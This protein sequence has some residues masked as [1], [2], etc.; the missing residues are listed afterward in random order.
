MSETADLV[1][2]H[3]RMFNERDWSI[4]SRIYSPDVAVTE[5]A[6]GTVVGIDAVLAHSQGFLAGFPDA[7]LEIVTLIDDGRRVVIEG[8]FVGTNTGPLGTPQGELPATGRSMRLPYADVWESEAGRITNHRVYYD[9]MDFAMQLG[10]M[11]D[12]APAT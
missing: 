6:F 10:L 1:R 4:A 3:Y 8:L 5:P 9:Q 11:P 12:P 2:E 7:R